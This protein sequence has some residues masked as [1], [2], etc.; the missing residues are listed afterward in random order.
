MWLI[1]HLL[2]LTHGL[3]AALVSIAAFYLIGALA[4]PPRW[5]NALRWPDS[6]VAGLA[7]YVL[8]CWVATSS[9]HIPIIY[10]SLFFGAV[11][12]GLIAV[13]F[14][15]L[16]STLGVLRKSV[17][18]RESL[19]TLSIIYVCAYLLV[20]PPASPALLTLP[21]DGALDLVTYARYAKQ[22]L[23]FG[24]STVDVAT[25]EHLD[26]PASTYVLAWHSLFFLGDPLNAAMPLLFMM[27]AV[28]G[29]FAVDLGRSLFRLSWRAAM[30][31]GVLAVCTPMFRWALATYSLGE[32][33][34]ATSVLYLSRVVGTAVATRS[35]HGSILLSMVASGTLCF[36]SARSAVGSPRSIARALA[37]AV[38]HFSPM[39][40][41]GLPSGIPPAASVPDSVR[42]ALLL[43]LPLVPLGWAASAYAL[44]RYAAAD[45]VA[46]PNDL[47]LARA[48]VAYV[49]V[50]MILGNVAD[51]AVRSHAP[52]RWPGGWQQL[53][54]VSSMP[55]RAVTLKVADEPN[56]LSTMLAMYYLPGRKAEVIGRDV[57]LDD[58]PFE[59]VSRQQPM[60]IHNI[61]CVGVGH[62]D[63]VTVPGVGCVLMAPPSMTAGTSYPF[64]RTFL[65]IRYGR[66]TPREPAG[67]WN[68]QPT[69]NL[70]LTV[71]PERVP[72]DREMYVN[73]RASPSGGVPLQVALRWGK[74]RSGE[75]VASD[76][77][78][79]S[80]AVGSSD[81]SGN[82]LWNLPVSIDFADGRTMLFH[83]LALTDSPRGV[84]PQPAR[85]F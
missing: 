36:F 42:S 77:Q 85:V 38:H 80:L 17:E 14:G 69:L 72:L 7:L 2:A 62:D 28:F 25:F 39:A 43:A 75:V 19:I 64:N 57:D 15:W 51:Q 54:N 23:L 4:L 65:F 18:M 52:A 27:T 8:L 78:W 71:D 37:D 49:A 46:A 29:V 35:L 53:G 76:R 63:T 55:F 81:W 70:R 40:L 82:R 1:G 5:Q 20:H 9:R 73:F 22:L 3:A 11:L 45:R 50:A 13:R 60:F 24:T 68:T 47:H 41:F 26:S 84:V 61:S 34:F 12:W 6:I 30:L 66:M 31:I 83:E 44:R 48:L 21:P 59:S 74:D 10:V 33:T 16:Q 56:G 32:L 58:L 67:R 79:F